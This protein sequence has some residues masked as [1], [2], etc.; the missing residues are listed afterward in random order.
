MC[1]GPVTKLAYQ[2]FG[3]D[4]SK[5]PTRSSDMN[6]MRII[7]SKH[8]ILNILT[9]MQLNT[10]NRNQDRLYSAQALCH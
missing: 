4:L 6:V 10:G 1:D 5:W 9:I 7:A 2:H 3:Y 8:V